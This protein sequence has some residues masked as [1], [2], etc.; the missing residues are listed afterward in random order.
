MLPLWLFY[1]AE[2]GNDQELL[3]RLIVL[4]F[5]L[6]ICLLLSPFG[7]GICK[8]AHP[9]ITDDAETIGRGNTEIEVNGEYERLK[10]HGMK[11]TTI[12]FGSTVTY[13]LVEDGDLA[14]SFPYLFTHAKYDRTERERGFGDVLIEC[15]WRFYGKNDLS[16]AL[17]PGLLLPFGD[18][19]KGLG[20][21]KAA[22]QIFAI[23]TKELKPFLVHV[24]AGYLLNKN[25]LDER[26]DLWHLSLAGE[27]PIGENLTAVANVGMDRD[28][29]PAHHREQSFILGGLI[30]ALTKSVAL[31]GGIKYSASGSVHSWS[32]LTGLTFQF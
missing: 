21:G 29:D 19:G 13:G 23:A 3:E 32:L 25:R 24:N 7:A 14:V 31:D 26:E 28:P 10:N 11:E 8:A 22:Y 5:Y 27:A 1:W 2:R 16:L 9:L 20:T 18:D 12:I 17:K 15:K 4:K 30:W 6:V